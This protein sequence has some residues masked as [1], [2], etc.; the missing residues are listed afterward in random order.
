MFTEEQT[1]GETVLHFYP[2]CPIQ[3]IKVHD[4]TI[5]TASKQ[6]WWLSIILHMLIISHITIFISKNAALRILFTHLDFSQLLPLIYGMNFNFLVEYF[7]LLF[8]LGLIHLFSYILFH[9]PLKVSSWTTHTSPGKKKSN[10]KFIL[11]YNT[12]IWKLW[13][14]CWR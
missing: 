7:R 12:L 9:F 6:V 4:C 14:L 10:F 5:S 2:S 1:E 8:D 13:D 11:F 3:A